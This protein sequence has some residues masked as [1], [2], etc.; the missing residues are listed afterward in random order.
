MK[1]SVIIPTYNEENVILDCLESL[2]RQTY[3]DFEIIVVDDGSKDKTLFYL[4]NLEKRIRDLKVIRQKHKGAGA[5]R[6][7]GAKFARGEILVFVDADMTFDKDFINRLVDPILK[8]KAKGT[9]SKEE[10]VLNWQNPIARYWNWNEGWEDKK[11]HKK[12]YPDWQP[13]FRAILKKEF[14]R[15]GGFE[16]GGYDDDWTLTEKL[17]YMAINAPGA[18]FYHK[19]P[20]SLKEV[21]Y[22]AKWVGKRKYK[23]GNIGK[24]L[25]LFRYS[26]PVS[27]FKGFLIGFRKK[28]LGFLIFKIVYDFAIYLGIIESFFGKNS[29]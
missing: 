17:G 2:G 11:R 20:S 10:Y 27:I 24:I 4:E 21:F 29:K 15:V 26:F 16:P 14:D 3:R 12:N 6:N 13:V 25:S 22:H 5:A 28:D 7:K 19:N 18:I 8:K 1:V 23:F 9:F